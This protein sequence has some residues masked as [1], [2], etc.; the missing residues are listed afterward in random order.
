VRAEAAR[1]GIPLYRLAVEAGTN[2]A[3][4]SRILNGRV[5]PPARLREQ[6][7]TMLGITKI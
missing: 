7:A 3:T 5:S 6:L 4:L 2:P 1:R